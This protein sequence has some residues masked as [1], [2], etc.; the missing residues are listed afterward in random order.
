M[1]KLSD[2]FEINNYKVFLANQ[3]VAFNL[4]EGVIDKIIEEIAEK[5]PTFL[6][7]HYEEMASINE[8]HL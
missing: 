3:Y 1:V 2:N 4:I 7:P 6:I 5:N 8:L